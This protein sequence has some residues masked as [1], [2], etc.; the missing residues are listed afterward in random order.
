MLNLVFM[1][2]LRAWLRNLTLTMQAMHKKIGLE[3]AMQARWLFFL[4]FFFFF[5]LLFFKIFQIFSLFSWW[6]SKLWGGW[7]VPWPFF[8]FSLAIQSQ[9]KHV[10]LQLFMCT[11]C[12]CGIAKPCVFEWFSW[13]TSLAS[14]RSQVCFQLIS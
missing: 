12:P 9:D 2:Y 4:L 8:L 7:V 10:R 6:I 13:K 3:R 14:S 1:E 5:L 11:F